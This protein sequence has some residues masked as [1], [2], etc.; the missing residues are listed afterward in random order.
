M[1]V[2]LILGSGDRWIIPLAASLSFAALVI[3]LPAG[4]EYL[5][6]EEQKRS[7]GR[8][9]SRKGADSWE[10]MPATKVPSTSNVQLLDA[11]DAGSGKDT[12]L[13]RHRH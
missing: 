7:L 13:P 2:L 10:H 4:Y 8:L 12:G 6:N 11:A 1:G 9:F 3:L 5:L